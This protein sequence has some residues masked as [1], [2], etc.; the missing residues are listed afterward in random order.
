MVEGFVFVA[1]L[2]GFEVLAA[3]FGKSTRDAE[4]WFTHAGPTS[5]VNE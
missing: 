2:V 3:R 5:A 1:S 4:D